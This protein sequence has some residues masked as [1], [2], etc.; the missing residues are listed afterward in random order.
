MRKRVI[1]RKPLV[2]D[3][4]P[5]EV[6]VTAT[7]ED[8]VKLRVTIRA[9]YGTHSFVTINGL[10]NFDYYYNYG[11]W[12]DENYSETADTIEITPRILTALIRFARN[13]GWSPGDAPGCLACVLLRSR[14]A[15]LRNDEVGLGVGEQST[16][17]IAGPQY[18]RIP[19]YRTHRAIHHL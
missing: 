10:R 12:T 6:S 18:T 9:G 13:N 4:Q 1:R 3:G 17:L 7:Y 19:R 11:Y 2:V 5:Y 14:C 8:V 15:S 16:G